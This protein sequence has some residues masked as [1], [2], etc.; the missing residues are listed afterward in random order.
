MHEA[1]IGRDE[2]VT[3]GLQA[4][5]LHES[6]RSTVEYFL[7]RSDD[8]WRECCGSDCLPCISQVAQAVDVARGL[9]KRGGTR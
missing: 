3:A 2:A 8:S 4:A 6:D 1:R 5:R 9:L 7:D